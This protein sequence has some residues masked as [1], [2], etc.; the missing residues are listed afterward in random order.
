MGTVP[1]GTGEFREAELLLLE[2]HKALEKSSDAP[3][4]IQQQTIQRVIQLYKLWKQEE[5]AAEWQDK[6]KLAPV[7]VLEDD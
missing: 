7:D 4:D 5:K 1:T 6:L 2:S 3:L